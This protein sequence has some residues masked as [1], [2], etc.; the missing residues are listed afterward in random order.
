MVRSGWTFYDE[1]LPGLTDDFPTTVEWIRALADGMG[2]TVDTVMGS[3]AASYPALRAGFALGARRRLL[4]G[5]PRLT[6]EEIQ[7]YHLDA[8]PT[9]L[10]RGPRD[11][12]RGLRLFAG[13]EDERDINTAIQVRREMPWSRM[14]IVDGARH[15]VVELLAS[16]GK[17]QRL[18]QKHS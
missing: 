13:S 1:G 5:L 10:F 3:S 4:F 7:R 15:N 12:G 8:R 17:L 9:G 6:S 2:L 16:Q 18:L 14:V 11:K